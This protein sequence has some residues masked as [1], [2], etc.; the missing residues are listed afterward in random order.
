MLTHIPLH[1]TSSIDFVSVFAIVQSNKICWY[2]RTHLMDTL[3]SH[4]EHIYRVFCIYIIFKLRFQSFNPSSPVSKKWSHFTYTHYTAF[5]T[6]GFRKIIDMIDIL[7]SHQFS[8]I[9]IHKVDRNFAR[10]L[11]MW[12]SSSSCLIDVFRLFRNNNNA[13]ALPVITKW[14]A[15]R[16][17]YTFMETLKPKM[18][19]WSCLYG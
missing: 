5:Q 3:F 17:I 2:L 15:S 7:C 8:V 10:S 16:C 18:L 19:D 11:L 14:G 9:C 6:I 4:F 13:P 1:A 12:G